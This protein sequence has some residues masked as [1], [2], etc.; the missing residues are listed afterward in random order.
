MILGIG[1]FGGGL[2]LVLGPHG[3]ILPLPIS[4]LK[5]SPFDSYFGPGLILFTVQDVWPWIVQMGAGS[6]AGWYS[7]DVIDNRRQPSADRIIPTL[8]T[9]AIGALFPAVPGSIDGFSTC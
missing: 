3:E 2:A 8:Q 5:G 9:I 1:A 7:D 4:L 6:R